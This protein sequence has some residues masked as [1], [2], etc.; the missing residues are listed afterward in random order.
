M[1]QC[2][3]ADIVLKECIGEFKN[4]KKKK[5]RNKANDPNK[6]SG[7]HLGDKIIE[8]QFVAADTVSSFHS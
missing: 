3:K 8:N 4:L 6:K 2:S 1:D 7:D 5:D